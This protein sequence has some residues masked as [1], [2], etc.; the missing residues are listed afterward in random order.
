LVEPTAQTRAAVAHA[1]AHVHEGYFE[2]IIGTEGV[3][4]ERISAAG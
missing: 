4:R 2:Y 3:M 1:L